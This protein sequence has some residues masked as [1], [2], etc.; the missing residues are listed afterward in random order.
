M[1]VC[2]IEYGVRPGMEGRL[3][4]A[5]ASLVPEIQ[6]IGAASSPWI[7]FRVRRAPG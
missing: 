5:F 3:E 2:I 7:T 4:E 6:A 1:I